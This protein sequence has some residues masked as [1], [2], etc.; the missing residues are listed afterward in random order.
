MSGT[1]PQAS[2]VSVAKATGA[3]YTPPPLADFLARHM[4]AAAPPWPTARPLRVCDPAVGRGELLLPLLARLAARGAR[5]LQVSGYDTDRDALATTAQRVARRFPGLAL[6]LQQA[7][8]LEVRPADG[9]Y[10]LVIANP[11]YVRT[12]H[13]GAVRAQAL[14]ARFGLS[15]RVDLHHAFLLGLARVLHGGGTA[16]FIVSNRFLTTQA[17]A[18]VRRALQERFRLHRVW[19][20]GDSR[21]FDAAVLPALVL[22]KGRRAS[23]PARVPFTSLYQ[24]RATPRRQV[25]DPVAALEC[26]GPVGVADG[27]CF[28]VRHGT[29]HTGAAASGV[30]R[31]SNASVERWLAT[32]QAHSWG[33]F[34]DAGPIRVGVKTCADRVFIRT[35]WQALPRSERPELL[36]PLVTHRDARPFRGRRAAPP[37]QILYPHCM[38]GNRRQAVD[39]TRYPRSRAYLDAHRPTLERRRYV[40]RAGRAWYEI[41]VPQ[42]PGAWARPKL[43]FRDIAAEPAFWLEL[44]HAVVNGDCYWLAARQPTDIDLLWLAAAVGNSTFIQH[45]YDCRFANRLYAG[46]RR[47]MTQYVTEFPLPAPDAAPGRALI[48]LA[49]R[50]YDAL[51]HGPTAALERELDS[52]VWRAFGF[53]SPEIPG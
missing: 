21:L 44:D 8:F 10:D 34:G 38:V 46:R 29:L 32:V 48:A 23:P 4:V 20:L 5:A 24:S 16:G 6:H 40:Q 36:R 7:D 15:G 19:D 12:Q 53:R 9:P 35:D 39:L 41:W 27:R 11:P 30:W 22:V 25:A 1:P 42:D 45:Y 26:R 17:G 52:Q 33:T 37:R 18:D 13:L 2:R 31:L 3:V 28:R 14:A 47:F 51:P 43:V 49:R 50:I